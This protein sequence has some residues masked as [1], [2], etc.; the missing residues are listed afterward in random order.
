MDENDKVGLANDHA[1]TGADSL[2]RGKMTL[3]R[4]STN[5]TM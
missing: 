2:T 5:E 3:Q 4:T 1:K